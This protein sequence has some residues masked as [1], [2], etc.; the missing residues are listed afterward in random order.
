MDIKEKEKEDL[1]LYICGRLPKEKLNLAYITWL[2]QNPQ[3]EEIRKNIIE[4]IKYIEFYAGKGLVNLMI[5]PMEKS[6]KIFEDLKLA[7]PHNIKHKLLRIGLLNGVPRQHQSLIEAI[8]K[9]DINGINEHWK[10]FSNYVI[11]LKSHFN[12]PNLPK[13]EQ[14]VLDK[15]LNEYVRLKEVVNKY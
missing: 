8:A 2:N 13:G 11:M 14:M 9:R 10:F 1:A 3:V 4:N 6:E 12:Y 5:E 7:F 15:W